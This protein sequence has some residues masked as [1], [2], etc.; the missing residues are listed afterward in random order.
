MLNC[1]DYLKNAKMPSIN[2]PDHFDLE[3]Y[4]EK[5]HTKYKNHAQKWGK[6]DFRGIILENMR[7]KRKCRKKK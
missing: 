4:M 3:K 5:D 1:N 6:G 2:T 7:K